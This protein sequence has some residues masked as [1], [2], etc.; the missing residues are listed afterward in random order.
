MI[1]C[2]TG[3]IRVLDA[4]F[5]LLDVQ[6]VGY[7]IDTPLSTFCQLKVGDKI[8]LWTNLVVGEDAKL[9]YGFLDSNDRY[10]FGF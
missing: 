8:T 6:G 10:Y 4:P 5:V 2:L 7:E 9:L 3:V 1:G